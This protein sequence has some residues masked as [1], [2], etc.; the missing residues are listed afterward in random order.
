MLGD[1]IEIAVNTINLHFFDAESRF[2]DLVAADSISLRRA[3]RRRG[4]RHR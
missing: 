2:G 4:S 3:C 1:T